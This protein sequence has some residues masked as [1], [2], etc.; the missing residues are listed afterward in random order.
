MVCVE[1][2]PLTESE[3]LVLAG[4]TQQKDGFLGTVWHLCRG[5]SRVQL[6]FGCFYSFWKGQYPLGC[7]SL[8]CL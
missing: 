7:Q 8:V 4:A 1:S 5:Y 3:G 2:V 6:S